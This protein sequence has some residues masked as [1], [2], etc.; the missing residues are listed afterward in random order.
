MPVLYYINF[1]LSEQ[2]QK[3][4]GKKG[5]K[6]KNKRPLAK[7]VTMAQTLQS[8]CGGYYRVCKIGSSLSSNRCQKVLLC[9][10]MKQSCLLGSLTKWRVIFHLVQLL[11]SHCIIGIFILFRQS[12][13]WNWTA[14][15]RN[16]N[17][18]LTVKKSATTTDLLHSVM[19]EHHLLF[20]IHISRYVEP[21]V[22]QQS[23]QLMY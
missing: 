14:N 22:I 7:E 11:L 23:G 5:K 10:P 13:V 19:L 20:S 15:W 21:T 8:I 2:Q 9:R 4:G 17:L 18:T 1:F 3:R 16:P 6:K 12:W